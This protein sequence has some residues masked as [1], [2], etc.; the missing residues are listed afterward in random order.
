MKATLQGFMEYLKNQVGQPYVWGGQHTKLTPK[1]YIALIDR[2]EERTGGYRGESYAEA[3]KAFCRRKFAQGEEVLYAYDCSGL[4]AYYL[5]NLTRAYKSDVT[6]HTMYTRCKIA[7]KDTAP[8]AGWW[9]FRLNKKG[10]ATHVG[11]MVTDSML[12]EA[13][14]RRDG[15]AETPFRPKSWDAW[16]IPRVFAEE[17]QGQETPALPS[18]PTGPEGA[19]EGVEVLGGSVHVRKGDSVKTEVLFTA[20]KG[21]TFPLLGR[22]NSGWYKIETDRGTGYISHNPAYTRL[23]TL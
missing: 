5:Y 23:V 1:T 14:G 15:V 4:G 8:K 13:K 6:A 9:V 12:I 21:D 17:F 20:R 11:Y 2:R 3:A 10:R 19:R 18:V 22:G 7:P 16:G